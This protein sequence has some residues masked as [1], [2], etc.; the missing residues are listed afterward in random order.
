MKRDKWSSATRLR[1]T[2]H[3]MPLPLPL[4][5]TTVDGPKTVR[6]VLE[7]A[8]CKALAVQRIARLGIDEAVAPYERVRLHPGGSFMM[9]CVEGSGRV[10]LDGRWLT[11][12][13][14]WACMAPPRV[15]N[16]FHALT[17]KPWRFLWLRYDEPM[18]VTPLVSAASPVRVKVMAAQLQRVWEGLRGE[19]ESSRDSKALHHWI[20]LVQHH[21]R[22]LAEPWRRDERLRSLWAKV[23]ASIADDW[24]VASL[25]HEA[26]VSEEHFRRL[27]WKELGR[28]PIAHLT[29]L[30]IRAAQ[31]MLAS[32]QDKQ[33][34]IAQMV[35]YRS[36]IAFSRAFRRWVG[37][38]PSEYRARV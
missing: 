11:I 12:G 5:E 21:A 4:T 10:L 30:R 18:F 14:G 24:S 25:A 36:P 35:G 28:S 16:A 17:R 8:D 34:V 7:A 9:I 2:G 32:N 23:H 19:W 3:T 29:S 20:E 26:H 1:K 31:A 27:C 37:C 6:W 38:L 15:P 33:E 13:A 22:R